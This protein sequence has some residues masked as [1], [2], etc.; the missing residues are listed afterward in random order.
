[1]TY[2]FK[3]HGQTDK[4]TVKS[5]VEAGNGILSNYHLGIGTQQR[6]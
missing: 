6:R 4:N 1:M 3:M 5:N 2:H